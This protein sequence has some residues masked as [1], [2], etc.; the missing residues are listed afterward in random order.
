MTKKASYAWKIT[1]VIGE[2]D[3][4]ECGLVG[5]HNL[6]GE[7]G[8][9]KARFRMYDDDGNPIY[10]GYITGDFDGFEPLDDFGTPNAGCTA[11]KY[12]SGSI[13]TPGGYL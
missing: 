7:F 10:E 8:A 3:S 4:T 13:T 1:K 12:L 5:P 2:N 11:I 6:G 9:N